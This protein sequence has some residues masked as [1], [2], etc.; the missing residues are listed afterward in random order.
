MI[1]PMSSLYYL[2]RCTTLLLNSTYPR[3]TMSWIFDDSVGTPVELMPTVASKKTELT[4]LELLCSAR[5][6]LALKLFEEEE[7]LPVES[8]E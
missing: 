7:E 4:I 6:M 2:N 5:L 8:D 1:L 3:C